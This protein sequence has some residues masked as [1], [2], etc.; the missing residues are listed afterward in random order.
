MYGHG[1]VGR[2][3]GS[4]DRS[5]G[6][7]ARAGRSDYLIQGES[8]VLQAGRESDNRGTTA[9]NLLAGVVS[10]DDSTRKTGGGLA[11]LPSAWSITHLRPDSR[12]PTHPPKG[13]HQKREPAAFER[14]RSGR[15]VTQVDG[16][17]RVRTTR[18]GRPGVSPNS[19]VDGGDTRC[20]EIP[21]PLGRRIRHI[22]HGTHVQRTNRDTP[23]LPGGFT[24]VGRSGPHAPFCGVRWPVRP[25][26]RMGKP[27]R[28][29][30]GGCHRI[31]PC[32]LSG[33][34]FSTVS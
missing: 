33:R 21:R 18:K 1:T 15:E 25:R 22:P 3:N 9:T 10:Q 19:L 23:A 14:H 30:R 4:S 26:A 20:K 29:R 16:T 6:L 27:R 2:R 13:G 24:P 8:P 11:F 28:S 7:P 12:P 5:T 31:V 17:T 34:S 32:F